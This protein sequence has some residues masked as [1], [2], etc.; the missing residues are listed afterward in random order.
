MAVY[1]EGVATLKDLGARLPRRERP[2]T[3]A[4]LLRPSQRISKQLAIKA[5]ATHSDA[6]ELQQ[7]LRRVD[8]R[9][10]KCL[11][12]SGCHAWCVGRA[13]P[14]GGAGRWLA[15]RQAPLLTMRSH[16]RMLG[17]V[18]AAPTTTGERRALALGDEGNVGGPLAAGRLRVR[19]GPTV[20][21]RVA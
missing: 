21:Q 6:N 10:G 7:V 17:A 8:S 5:K 20:A 18:S 3:K 13:A 12:P 1:G 14:N 19:E 15:W 9:A 11:R 2:A 4:A 16:S